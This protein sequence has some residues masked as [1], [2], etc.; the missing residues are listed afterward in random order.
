M[1]SL[2][3]FPRPEFLP[4]CQAPASPGERTLSAFQDCFQGGGGQGPPKSPTESLLFHLHFLS[5]SVYGVV[6]LPFVD[7]LTEV[8]FHLPFSRSLCL[9]FGQTTNNDSTHSHPH[10]CGMCGPA[11]PVPR[12]QE[13]PAVPSLRAPSPHTVSCSVS[14]SVVACSSAA[15][16]PLGSVLGWLACQPVRKVLSPECLHVSRGDGRGLGSSGTWGSSQCG[17]GIARPRPACG[18]LGA[19]WDSMAVPD[20]GRPWVCWI[21]WKF[22]RIF[23]LWLLGVRGS[24]PSGPPLFS[25]G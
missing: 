13:G 16:S 23:C 22:Q 1:G 5:S 21:A 15:T 20:L 3:T 2:P 4:L 7:N 6:I 19:G 14:L 10:V 18:V 11:C 9:A 8:T 24:E 17:C 12:P 25:G